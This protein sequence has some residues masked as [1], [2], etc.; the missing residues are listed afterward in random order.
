M[1]AAQTV[2]AA[3]NAAVEGFGDNLLCSFVG[4]SY[5]RGT[6]K[7]TS[8][9]DLFVITAHSDH[10]QERRFAERLRALHLL[11]GLDF[12]HCG[13]AF[14]AD[15]LNDLLGFTEA[16]IAAVPAVQRSACYLADCP[17][18][19]FRKGDVVFKF[20]A[21][22]KIGVHD[23]AGVL[24]ALEARA[25]AYFSTWPMP[26]IQG[27]KGRLRLPPDSPQHQLSYLWQSRVAT[28]EWADTPVGIGLERWFG[29]ELLSRTDA[30]PAGCQ[31]A[32]PPADGATCP[33]PTAD[34][35]LAA[36]L[37][38]QCLAFLHTEPEGTR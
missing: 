17:L 10:G 25:A 19:V 6:N 31:D 13:E 23:P 24:P 5:A 30:L 33:L 22:P 15:T 2:A 18:S 29:T 26:R 3:S 32:Q 7:P 27:Y 9:I 16:S 28:A 36:S 14:T 4:G 21:D 12:D 8:D 38:A 35:T 1:S 37:T 34:E 20:L 11:A